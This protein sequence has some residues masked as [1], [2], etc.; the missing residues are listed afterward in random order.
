MYIYIYIYRE[1]ERLILIID[2]NNIDNNNGIIII[3]IINILLYYSYTHSN[4]PPASDWIMQSTCA[5]WSMRRHHRPLSHRRGCANPLSG[6]Q[7]I[8]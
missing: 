3:F 8:R 5:C 7:R 4:L 1:R 6:P 2:I